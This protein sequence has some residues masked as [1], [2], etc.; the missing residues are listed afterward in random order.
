MDA[1]AELAAFALSG[2]VYVAELRA[3]TA[4]ALPVPGPAIILPPPD[5]L[6]IAYVAKGALRVV[7]AT[8]EGDRALAEPEDPQVTYGLAEFI[9]AEEI[10]E[11]VP[12]IRPSGRARAAPPTAP[13]A[14]TRDIRMIATVTQ[15]GGPSM[16]GVFRGAPPMNHSG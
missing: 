12:A 4:R 16:S 2:K 14:A 10:G 8:G 9:A 15:P 3:G 7:D 6:H 11:N 5:G 13:R 1:A